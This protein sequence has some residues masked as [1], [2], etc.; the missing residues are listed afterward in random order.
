MNNWKTCS[1]K[2]TPVEKLSEFGIV[3]QDECEHC[4]CIGVLAEKPDEK[5]V[6]QI[7]AQPMADVIS[8][9]E[10]RKRR[11]FERQMEEAALANLENFGTYPEGEF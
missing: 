10:Y 6:Y 1:H 8:L 5:G 2:W 9:C 4:G 3:Y 7:V 11:E